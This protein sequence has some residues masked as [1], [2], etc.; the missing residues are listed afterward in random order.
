M[1]VEEKLP[2]MK[3][4]AEDAA[5]KTAMKTKKFKLSLLT[6]LLWK[7]K[8]SAAII[9]YQGLAMNLLKS[10]IPR[11]LPNIMAIRRKLNLAP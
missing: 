11:Y 10:F 4:N 2:D 9:S 7:Y 3:R 6:G 5:M 8:L 1:P